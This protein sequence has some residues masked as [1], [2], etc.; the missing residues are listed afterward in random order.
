MRSQRKLQI[1]R[2]FSWHSTQEEASRF[3]GSFAEC[4]HHSKRLDNS[5]RYTSAH[6]LIFLAVGRRELTSCIAVTYA[7]QNGRRKATFLRV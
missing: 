1:A 4:G 3:R 6:A 2:L 5:V 7:R